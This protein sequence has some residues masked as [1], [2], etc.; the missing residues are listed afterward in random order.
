MTVWNAD[1]FGVG[2]ISGL[3]FRTDPAT[4]TRT[5]RVILLVDSYEWWIKNQLQKLD[6]V[7][8]DRFTEFKNS[9]G[10][11]V[12]RVFGWIEREKDEYM[13]FV[14]LEFLEDGREILFLG[15]SSKK[16]GE[17]IAGMLPG[18]RDHIDCQR[19]EDRYQDLENAVTMDGDPS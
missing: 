16:Y 14:N 8:W 11:R 18:E 7:E 9:N 13:D 15:T 17:K 1:K 10:Q 5:Q 6:F 2:K 4:N 3:M 12:T 19:V